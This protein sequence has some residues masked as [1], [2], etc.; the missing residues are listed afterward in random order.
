MTTDECD[1]IVYAALNTINGKMYV[2]KT[3]GTFEE[4]RKGH[5]HPTTTSLISV[6]IRKYG[7]EHFRW[8]II[9]Q[10]NSKKELNK[11]EAHWIKE[12]NTYFDNVN[13]NSQGYNLTTGS[14]NGGGKHSQITS[15]RVFKDRTFVGYRYSDEVLNRL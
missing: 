6:A 11:L 1:G 7:A 13:D 5:L 15:I 9:D 14:E 8:M 2:G 3:I 10:A 4:R 12:Y